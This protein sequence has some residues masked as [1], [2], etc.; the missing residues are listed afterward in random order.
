MRIL[1]LEDDL[2]L[3]GLLVR[4]LVREGHAVDDVGLIEDARWLATENPYDVA[5]LDVMVPDGD[6]FSL[7]RD[8]REAGWRVPVLFL[9]ARDAVEDRVRG[10]DAGG[11][12]YLVKP[13]ALVELLARLR[14]LARRGPVE[15][16]AILV[17]GDVLLDP[18]THRVTAGG[19]LLDLTPRQRSL[20]EA[21]LRQPEVVLS[22][23][24]I[25]DQVWDWA[26][27]GSP[28]IIDVYIR[29]LREALGTGPERPRIETIRGAGYVL[30][31]PPATTRAARP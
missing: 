8:L 17:A 20:L 24:R 9:T 28:R 1:L 27:D 22:R 23:Q 19:R 6:G 7:C 26:F 30:R 21:F 2:R 12:D 31:V 13:F 18:A 3:R 10:L 29:S 14:S 11:D 4:G 5:I 16:P 15:R 25:L